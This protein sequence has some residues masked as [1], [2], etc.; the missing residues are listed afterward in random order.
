MWRCA[1]VHDASRQSMY[2]A[3]Y[4]VLHAAAAVA[5]EIYFCMEHNIQVTTTKQIMLQSLNDIDFPSNHLHNMAESQLYFSDSVLGFSIFQG[6]LAFYRICTYEMSYHNLLL[7]S[8]WHFHICVVPNWNG[9][10]SC[11]QLQDKEKERWFHSASHYW[12]MISVLRLL[13]LFA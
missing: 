3:P 11:V 4:T 12:S 2:A 13:L 10:V 8:K 6:Q 1:W 7:I 9:K 5:L